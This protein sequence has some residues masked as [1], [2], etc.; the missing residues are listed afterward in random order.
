M[1]E[2]IFFATVSHFFSTVFHFFTTSPSFF[3]TIIVSALIFTLK[4]H[5]TTLMLFDGLCG[6]RVKNEHRGKKQSLK[7][8]RCGEKREPGGSGKKWETVA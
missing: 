3:A 7:R 8:G 4:Q 5:E 6:F 1:D 2:L